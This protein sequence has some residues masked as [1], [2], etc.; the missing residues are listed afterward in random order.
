[1]KKSLLNTKNNLDQVA[2]HLQHDTEIVDSML[3]ALHEYELALTLLSEESLTTLTKLSG[4]DL[5][6]PVTFK[7]ALEKFTEG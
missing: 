7:R 1:M 6:T 5:Y 3:E 2:E 4:L